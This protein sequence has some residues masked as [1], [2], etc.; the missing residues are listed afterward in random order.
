MKIYYQDCQVES[1]QGTCEL[2]NKQKLN[3]YISDDRDN[4]VDPNRN[5]DDD[6][7]DKEKITIIE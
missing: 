2:E 3:D 1:C 7:D 5:D 4:D 6:D